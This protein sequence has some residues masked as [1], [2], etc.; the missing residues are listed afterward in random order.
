MRL[1]SLGLAA[2]RFEQRP[3]ERFARDLLANFGG[4]VRILLQ[5]S[6]D[7]VLANLG[8][9]LR[10]DVELLCGFRIDCRQV[11]AGDDDVWIVGQQLLLCFGSTVSARKQYQ[12]D[13]LH[14]RWQPL[15]FWLCVPQS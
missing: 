5:F 13:P 6:A 15:R 1:P 10:V 4:L 9:C 11:F 3:N 7:A 2:R 12:A 8:S 14:E